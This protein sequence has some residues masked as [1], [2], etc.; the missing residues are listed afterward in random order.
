MLI[1][2]YER[3]KK[4]SVTPI[5]PTDTQSTAVGNVKAV[6]VRYTHNVETKIQ[7]KQIFQNGFWWYINPHTGNLTL[8][9]PYHNYGKCYVTDTT[10]Q[11][12]CKS[13]TNLN[14]IKTHGIDEYIKPGMV[15]NIKCA[16]SLTSFEGLP[17]VHFSSI[18]VD[19]TDTQISQDIVKW[20]FNTKLSALSVQFNLNL[21]TYYSINWLPLLVDFLFEKVTIFVKIPDE[22]Y[23]KHI[24]AILFKS[25]MLQDILNRHI[26]SRDILGC[27][28]ALI[29]AGLSE[30]A[31]M[32]KYVTKKG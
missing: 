5:A 3:N 12:I 24:D 17:A 22:A 26:Q 4:W 21:T 1:S 8:G 20:L 2:W 14:W 13:G 7:Y 25:Y 9:Q 19:C 15:L 23:I 30:F 16:E 27:Q 10:I 11:I 29:D 6:T 18:V 28:E 32:P 31:S